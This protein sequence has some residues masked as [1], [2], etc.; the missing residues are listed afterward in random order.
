MADDLKP[1]NDSETQNEGSEAAGTT[2]SAEVQDATEQAVTEP[3]DLQSETGTDD[4]EQEPADPDSEPA[5]IF[6]EMWGDEPGDADAGAEGAEP[7]VN[8]AAAARQKTAPRPQKKKPLTKTRKKPVRSMEDE[9][10]DLEEEEKQFDDWG[11]PIRKKKR[12]KKTRKLSCTLV[13]LT[14]ILA[15]SSVL[16]V[17]ILAVAKEMY[18][19][20]KDIQEKIVVIPQGAGTAEIAK[21]LEEEKLIS[22]PRVFRLV[23]R[24]N[25][26]DGQYIA[27]EHVLSASMSY[28]AMIEELCYNHVDEREYV[29][30]TFREGITLLDA[31]K[32]L[33]E[34]EV[35]DAEQFLFYFNAGG[36]G[37]RFEEYLPETTTNSL[38]FQRMEG[39]CFP[40]TYEFYVGEDPN[41]VAQKIYA[42]FDSKLTDGDYRKMEELNMT[43][44]EV[45]TLA[46]IVQ[47]EA[48]FPDSMRMVSSVFHNRLNNK[49]MFTKLQS[50]PTKKYANEVIA[51]NLEISNE[52][53]LTAYNTYE[54]QGLPPGAINNP[55]RDAIEATLYPD[56][57]PYY[58]FNANINTKQI[59]YSITYD[60]HLRHLAEVEQQ[61][62]E[63]EAAAN[64]ET[65]N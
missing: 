3:D 41:I 16:S 42:N 35:C 25:K 54:G 6:S 29:R 1:I 58:Y 9:L 7:E 56:D 39:Y 55:G 18:G 62:K 52:L 47:G 38:K 11:R 19:I 32:M 45:I 28:E 33:Q 17:A 22:L 10:K 5:D 15:L 65:V 4:A 59:Y 49:A 61:Y 57:T 2:D 30:V 23:S 20:D 64:G 40:D 24:M 44:D 37:F 48:P 43:L 12:R 36:Y 31:A 63:A 26:K 14:L 50:D 34:N 13:L 27:G 60:E 53:M 46:S 8:P 21:Q 51:P